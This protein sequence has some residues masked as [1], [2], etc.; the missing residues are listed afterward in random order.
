MAEDPPLT[1]LEKSK[2]VPAP[3]G[4][5][6]LTDKKV[7]EAVLCAPA[8]KEMTADDKKKAMVATLV[9]EVS[10]GGQAAPAEAQEKPWSIFLRLE[11]GEGG[12]R[13]GDLGLPSVVAVAVLREAAVW[14]TP[15]YFKAT[16]IAHGGDQ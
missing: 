15:S 12:G 5:H 6:D 4:G 13:G 7:M 9:A 2:L 14:A 10:G 11:G 8:Q 16:P 1:A 3:L